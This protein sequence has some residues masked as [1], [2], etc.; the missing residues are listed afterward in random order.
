M[1]HSEPDAR[2]L[3]SAH[4]ISPGDS[5]VQ[6]VIAVSPLPAQKYFYS[7][8]SLNVKASYRHT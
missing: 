4:F 8:H 5:L 7:F 2:H 1:I 6:G 3:N